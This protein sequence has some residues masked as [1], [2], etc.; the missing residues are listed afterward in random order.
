MGYRSQKQ[1]QGWKEC[2]VGATKVGC[3]HLEGGP[4]YS[5]YKFPQL[6]SYYSYYFL[7]Y[8]KFHSE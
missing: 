2:K 5:Y 1:E 4:Y 7:S 6:I 8:Y 3:S